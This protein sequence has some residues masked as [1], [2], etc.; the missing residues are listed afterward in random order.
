MKGKKDMEKLDTAE[1]SVRKEMYCVL[2]SKGLK[3]RHACG[4][5]WKE[6]VRRRGGLVGGAMGRYSG[7]GE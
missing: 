6:M 5:E 2:C 1:K 3:N 7:R 4:V